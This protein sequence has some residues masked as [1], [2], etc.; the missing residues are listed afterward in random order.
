MEHF[1][2]KAMAARLEKVLRMGGF[3]AHDVH[4][5]RVNASFTVAKDAVSSVKHLM[6][7]AGMTL[8][9][10]IDTTYRMSGGRRNGVTL[11]FNWPSN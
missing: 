4:V 7:L 1:N 3:K 5:T 11:F 6:S 2:S 8:R 10:V 9:T